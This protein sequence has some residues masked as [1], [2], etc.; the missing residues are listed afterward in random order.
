MISKEFAIKS[1]NLTNGETLTLE[2][3]EDRVE[4][5]A[6]MMSGL[7]G[8]SSIVQIADST[9]TVVCGGFNDSPCNPMTTPTPPEPPAPTPVPCPALK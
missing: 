2:K 7:G 3:A 9:C 5:Q 6:L 1:L 4:F 8:D